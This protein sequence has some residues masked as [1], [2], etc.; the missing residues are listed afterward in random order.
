MPYYQC[1]KFGGHETYK[2]TVT[3]ATSGFQGQ[4][5]VIFCET[6]DI[7]LGKKDFHHTAQDK[8]MEEQQ[9]KESALAGCFLIVIGLWL[10]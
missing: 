6:C 2:G 5:T 4:A 7:Q 10:L 1:P 9:G 3:S 8:L